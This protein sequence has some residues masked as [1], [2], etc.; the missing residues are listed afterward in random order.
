M[1]RIPDAI[2]RREIVYGEPKRPVD[3]LA[4]GQ[5]YH[6]AGRPTD[7]LDCALRIKDDPAGHDAL[8]TAVRDAALT[9]GDF[10]VLNRVNGVRELDDAQWRKGFDAAKASGKTRFALKFAKRLGDT[11]EIQRLELELGLRSP[12]EPAAEPEAAPQVEAKAETPA[13]AAEAA[14]QADEQAEAGEAP[15]EAEEPKADE[16]PAD[17][18]AGDEAKAEG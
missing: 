3:Y 7:A 12:D 1:T 8:V 6:E 17:D 16:T 4:L 9:R 18:A 13:A 11:A 2:S 15:A 5:A 10:F 14:P